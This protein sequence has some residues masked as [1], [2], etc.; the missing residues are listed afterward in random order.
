MSDNGTW[1]K[2]TLYKLYKQSYINQ[3]HTINIYQGRWVSVGLYCNNHTCPRTWRGHSLQFSELLEV[4][5]RH[6]RRSV[7]I[8]LWKLKKHIAIQ[9]SIYEELRQDFVY[10]SE[11]KAK[12][13]LE[14]KCNY[15][16]FREANFAWNSSFFSS[17]SSCNKISKV[18][19]TSIK[20]IS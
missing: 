10:H 13:F 14:N 16:W 15:L 20:E 12:C 19:V 17:L 9:C 4:P 7:S 8:Q 11:I 5:N 3:I 18:L 1:N 2:H 6:V